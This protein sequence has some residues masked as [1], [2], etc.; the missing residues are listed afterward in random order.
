MS[1]FSKEKIENVMMPSLSLGITGRSDCNSVDKAWLRR[2]YQTSDVI[3]LL[4]TV[5]KKKAVSGY[6]ALL[7]LSLPKF[8]SAWSR[9]SLQVMM[10]FFHAIF[11][12]MIETQA[13]NCQA[14]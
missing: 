6:Y 12:L 13:K 3:F 9:M 2:K 4:A 5:T 14:S 11:F 10:S 7:T 1:Y 8:P